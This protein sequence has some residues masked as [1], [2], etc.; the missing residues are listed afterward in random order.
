MKVRSYQII[1][2][3]DTTR[4]FV[5]LHSHPARVALDLA[6]LNID[7]P[8]FQFFQQTRAKSLSCNLVYEADGDLPLQRDARQQLKAFE[9]EFCFPFFAGN[10]LV[11]LMLLATKD[12]GDLFTPHDLRLLTELSSNLGL[13][14]NQIRLRHQLQ[15]VY[16]QDLMGRM[17]RGLAHDLNNLLTPV[18][19]LLQLLQ[20]SRMNQET[21]DE[22]LPMGLRNLQT[23]RTYVN[24]ALFFSPVL[25]SA[26]QTGVAG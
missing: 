10:D 13:L 16:E 20:E 7:S 9:P 6:D 25:P 11:G 17:S 22:L 26:R 18:Q 12:N 8:V 14:L 19:T 1:L 21:I 4:G 15:T 23:V 24:E 2:L 5:L 3:D